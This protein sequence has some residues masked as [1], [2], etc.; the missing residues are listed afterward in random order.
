MKKK[1]KT[2]RKELFQHPPDRIDTTLGGTISQYSL[3]RNSIICVYFFIGILSVIKKIKL[4][5]RSKLE[6]MHQ[7]ESPFVGVEAKYFSNAERI[8][9]F[10]AQSSVSN[11]GVIILTP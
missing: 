9:S 2:R 11:A 3:K 1:K 7:P 10:F 4:S 6:K 8:Y 5:Q